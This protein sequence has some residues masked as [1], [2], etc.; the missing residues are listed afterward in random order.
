M[1]FLNNN[2]K[3]PTTKNFAQIRFDLTTSEISKCQYYQ[4]CVV[5]KNSI[6]KTRV[7]LKH[8]T[9]KIQS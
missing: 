3:I 5:V 2:E 1:D 8:T 9:W 6:D 7:P 4:F